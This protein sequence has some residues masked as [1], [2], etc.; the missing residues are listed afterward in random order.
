MIGDRFAVA[1]LGTLGALS[2]CAVGPDYRPP[3]IALGAQAPLVSVTPT[4]ESTAEPPDDWW[5]L[6]HDAMLDR[7]I[8]EVFTS[9]TD[10]RI[11]TANLSAARSVL[12]FFAPACAVLTS[13]S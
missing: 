10:L 5:Q 2:G 7:L 8:A 11:A 4:A 12:S 1:L 9:N 13:R 6:Y 3:T